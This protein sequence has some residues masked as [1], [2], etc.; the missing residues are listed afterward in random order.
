[1]HNLPRRLRNNLGTTSPLNRRLI[2]NTSERKVE[3]AASFGGA[4]AWIAGITLALTIISITL[5]AAGKTYRV[6]YL[7]E[8]G[9][10]DSMLLWTPQDLVYLGAVS[11]LSTLIMALPVL[12]AAL[13]GTVVMIGATNKLDRLAR[14]LREKF[15][16]A[17][18]LTAKK[19]ETGKHE[20]STSNIEIQFIFLL[21]LTGLVL[22]ILS[23]ACLNYIARA[24]RLGKEHA[25]KDRTAIVEG[26]KDKIK[27]RDLIYATI[28]RIVHGKPIT[29]AGYALSCSEKGCLIFQK[30]TQF[31]KKKGK[32]DT[33]TVTKFIPLDN[34]SEFSMK[35]N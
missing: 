28:Q 14:Q 9:A 18:K 34:V 7:A 23:W 25:L 6:N 24:E 33:T 8:F 16:F 30:K 2:N 1:M 21:V 19:K 27:D 13:L 4:S 31:D 35:R 32:T 11:Q 26:D 22:F 29:E 12:V 17:P 15:G 10:V 3:S 20:A 5:Y